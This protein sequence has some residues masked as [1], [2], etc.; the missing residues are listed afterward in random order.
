[1]KSI[2][3][4]Y[5]KN[6]ILT[7][8]IILI[9]FVL[10]LG[11]YAICSAEWRDGHDTT[12]R[13]C[14]HD[15]SGSTKGASSYINIPILNNRYQTT[16]TITQVYIAVPASPCEEEDGDHHSHGSQW[17]CNNST[18]T[19]VKEIKFGDTVAFNTSDS[20]C[21]CIGSTFHDD[22]YTYSLDTNYSFSSAKVLC[23][24]TLDI[25]P[26]PLGNYTVTYHYTLPGS[27]TV[28]SNELTFT[29]P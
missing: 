26:A 17:Q 1:M 7:S 19:M 5:K 15:H 24:I 28:R 13:R 14:G 6:I 16:A 23:R 2:A 10:T 29:I 20:Y 18:E 11:F 4:S 27:A 3:I 9:A 25:N 22:G 8:G 12:Y 21:C